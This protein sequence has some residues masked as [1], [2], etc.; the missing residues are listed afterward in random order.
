MIT[1]IQLRGLIN[2]KLGIWYFKGMFLWASMKRSRL[3]LQ[4][5]NR[6]VDFYRTTNVPNKTAKTLGN[7]PTA[8]VSHH[9][10]YYWLRFFIPD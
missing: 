2:A 7:A 8:V 1:M 10:L 4:A 6:V 3:I 9:V 5:K